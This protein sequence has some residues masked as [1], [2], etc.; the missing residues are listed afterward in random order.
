MEFFTVLRG[1]DREVQGSWDMAGQLRMK[2]D[3]QVAINKRAY[4]QTHQHKLVVVT[5]RGRIMITRIKG[6]VWGKFTNDT[7]DMV[8][9]YSKNQR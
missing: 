3:R 5:N 8:N 6:M 2:R 9:M 4:N 7:A 1:E